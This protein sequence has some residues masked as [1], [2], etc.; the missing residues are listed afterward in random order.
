M[1]EVS[2]KGYEKVRKEIEL[3]Q[4]LNSITVELKKP[5][6][7]KINLTLHDYINK[8]PI[9]N[10]SLKLRNSSLDINDEG[11]T[12]KNGNYSYEILYDESIFTIIAVKD[13]FYSSQRNFVLDISSQYVTNNQGITYGNEPEKNSEAKIKQK[14][15]FLYLV[16]NDDRL[17]NQQT[18]LILYAN[19]PEYFIEIKDNFLLSEAIKNF[20]EFEFDKTLSQKGVISYSL[21]KKGM[22]IFNYDF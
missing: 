17:N 12:D 5:K 16:S 10:V 4:G 3:T 18:L 9:E 8:S 6:L 11:L 13:G 19:N 14:D 15:I 22:F 7:V 2:K 20:V 21:R 1:I